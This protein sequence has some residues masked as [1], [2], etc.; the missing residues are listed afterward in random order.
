MTK[1]PYKW[2]GVIPA[3]SLSPRYRGTKCS[4]VRGIE[5]KYTDGSERKIQGNIK[6][7]GNGA[8]GDRGGSYGKENSK[9][10]TR[11]L[12]FRGWDFRRS[13]CWLVAYF[14]AATLEPL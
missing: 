8:V 9:N 2:A 14:Y 13:L 12:V 4:I 10:Y 5:K 6:G 1:R 7:Y 11:V 3:S